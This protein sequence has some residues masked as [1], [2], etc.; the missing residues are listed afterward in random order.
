MS[1]T[2]GRPTQHRTGWHPLDPVSLGAGAAAV[3]FA[4]FHLL[5]IRFGGAE[6]VV[7]VVLLAAGAVGLVV[8]LRG[9]G[10]RGG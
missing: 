9:T 5:E 3:L 1:R 6:L 8:S 4:L 7:P 10:P 2:E